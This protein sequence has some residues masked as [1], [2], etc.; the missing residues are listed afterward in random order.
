MAA[1]GE[2]QDGSVRQNDKTTKGLLD[3]IN[4]EDNIKQAES[5]TCNDDEPHPHSSDVDFLEENHNGIQKHLMNLVGEIE[6]DA[7]IEH[8]ESHPAITDDQD[9]H[10][11]YKSSIRSLMSETEMDEHLSTLES[12]P[13]EQPVEDHDSY[14]SSHLL[15]LVTETEIDGTLSCMESHA[16]PSVSFL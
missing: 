16:P 12:T 4:T 5:I 1:A 6:N 10:D 15:S 8:C 9:D 14:K 11:S 7:N 3:D 13:S 2:T